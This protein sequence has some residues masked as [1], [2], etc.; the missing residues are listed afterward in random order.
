MTN[1]QQRAAALHALHAALDAAVR[2]AGAT[3]RLLQEA[4]MKLAAVGDE[5][6]GVVGGSTQQVDQE[7]VQSLQTAIGHSTSA[8]AALASA[9]RAAR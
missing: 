4:T 9:A 5:V 2:E 3:Q 1:A 8:I 7:L 6:I